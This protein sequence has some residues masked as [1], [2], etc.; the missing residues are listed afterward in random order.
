VLLQHGV[1]AVD[2]P[3]PRELEGVVVEAD[4]AGSVLVLLALRVGLADPEQGLAVAPA[5]VLAV[6]VPC[7]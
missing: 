7:A 2:V 6:L 5:G 4:I 1:E 3:A